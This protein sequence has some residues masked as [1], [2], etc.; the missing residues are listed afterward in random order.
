MKIQSILFLSLIYLL[1]SCSDSKEEMIV[2]DLYSES[3]PQTWKLVKMTGGSPNT[4]STGEDMSW[5]ESYIFK[6]D[7]SFIKTRFTEEKSLSGSGT[8]SKV[9]YDGG[10][11]GYLLEYHSSNPIIGSCTEGQE[12]LA[13]DPDKPNLI[14][15]W[16]SCDGPGLFY[17]RIK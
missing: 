2:Q 8:W 6:A 11:T 16:W 3:F 17:E 15:S 13:I 9:E 14:S 4:E 7:K 1:T 12:Y 5:Q 10:E